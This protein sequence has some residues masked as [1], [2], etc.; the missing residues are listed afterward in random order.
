MLALAFQA[1]KQAQQ[2]LAVEAT[3]KTSQEIGWEQ[4]NADST[5]FIVQPLDSD[6][7]VTVDK[8]TDPVVGSVG[9][10]IQQKIPTMFTAGEMA[11][12][13]WICASA[14]KLNVQGGQG[15]LWARPMY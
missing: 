15:P 5:L 7:W 14:C 2:V 6:V 4:K 10:C 1:V 8:E 13:R 3:A 12:A 9:F 11:Q